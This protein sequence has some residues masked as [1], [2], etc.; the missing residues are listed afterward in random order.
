MRRREFI[1]L[2]GGG[3]VWPLAA[4][5][6]TGHMR[7]IVML[8]GATENDPEAPLSSE[9]FHRSNSS[10]VINAP[11]A[12]ML[13]LTIPASL[14]ARADEVIERWRRGVIPRLHE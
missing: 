10:L 6:Q 14:L 3:A 11:T 1:T 12:S 7:R 8:V 13:S 5:A 9:A 2:L 4:R